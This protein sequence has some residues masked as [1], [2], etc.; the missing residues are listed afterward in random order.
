[1]AFD[2]APVLNQVTA[3]IERQHVGRCGAAIGFLARLVRLLGLERT[4]PMDDPH[5]VLRIHRQTD[6]LPEHPAVRQRLG[7]ERID[8]ELRR[9]LAGRLDD[10]TFSE[11]C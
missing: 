11:P 6:G 4:R 9:L 8:F 1:M 3:L 2:F 5:V 10:G 7:P